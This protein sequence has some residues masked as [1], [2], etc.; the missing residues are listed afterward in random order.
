MLLTEYDPVKEKEL[1]V[2]TTEMNTRVHDLTTLMEADSLTLEQAMDK[3]KV[4]EAD[5]VNIRMAFE[6]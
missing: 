1:L 2:K 3:L 5:R 6:K 4:L